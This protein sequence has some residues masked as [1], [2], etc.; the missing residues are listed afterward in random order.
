MWVLRGWGKEPTSLVLN[1][2]ATWS[3][4]KATSGIGPDNWMPC[5]SNSGDFVCNPIIERAQERRAGEVRAG[6]WQGKNSHFAA[7]SVVFFHR[8]CDQPEIL[9][10]S[11]Q[12]VEMCEH[13]G[14]GQGQPVI[15]QY[16]DQHNSHLLSLISHNEHCD[17]EHTQKRKMA[18]V[19]SVWSNSFTTTTVHRREMCV[20]W[21]GAFPPTTIEM[22]IYQ[23]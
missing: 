10:A 15:N 1:Y 17:G 13:G 3:H 21:C 23:L 7:F 8:V 9:Y 18:K 19:V 16:A 2:T 4:S 20:M 5:C 12:V 6:R 22:L 11:S 14:N